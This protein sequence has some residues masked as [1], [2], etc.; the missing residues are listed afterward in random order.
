MPRFSKLDIISFIFMAS[1]LAVKKE[2]RIIRRIH[3][4]EHQFIVAVNDH[5]KAFVFGSDFI[6]QV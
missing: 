3:K 1:S 6:Y 5:K 4:T 2:I